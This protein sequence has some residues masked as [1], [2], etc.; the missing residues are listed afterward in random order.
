M[1]QPSAAPPPFRRSRGMRSAIVLATAATVAY[2]AVAAAALTGSIGGSGF[3]APPL[4]AVEWLASAPWDPPV[5]APHPIRH[6]RVTPRTAH[7][8][9]RPQLHLAA[10]TATTPSPAAARVA[11]PA[12]V[13]RPAHRASAAVARTTGRATS[14][15]RSADRRRH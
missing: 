1:R 10:T 3:V 8:R 14:R 4:A 5:A 12:A 6:V 13:A 11:R 7:H 15:R 2:A 9:G